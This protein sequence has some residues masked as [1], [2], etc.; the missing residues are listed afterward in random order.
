MFSSDI[1]LLFNVCSTP[2]YTIHT[3]LTSTSIVHLFMS[4]M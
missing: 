3:L 2:I 1:H 4:V